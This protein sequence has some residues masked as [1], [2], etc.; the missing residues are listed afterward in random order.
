MSVYESNK[1]RKDGVR[2]GYNIYYKDENIGKSKRIT[3]ETFKTQKEALIAERRLLNRIESGEYD[4]FHGERK[5]KV[6]ELFDDFIVYYAKTGVTESTVRITEQSM[7][8]HFIGWFGDFYINKITSAHL[9]DFFVDLASKLKNYRSFNYYITQFFEYAKSKGIITVNPMDNRSKLKD[10]VDGA[11]NKKVEKEPVHY[12]EKELEVVLNVMKENLPSKQYTYFLL[13]AKTGLRKSEGLALYKEDIDLDNMRITVNKTIT[14]DRSG[15][16][17]TADGTKSRA[18]NDKAPETLPLDPELK[19]PLLE[20]IEKTGRYNETKFFFPS[21]RG[22]NGH[23]SMTAPDKWLR[24]FYNKHMEELKELGVTHRIKVHGFRH[25]FV[26]ILQ[27]S[28][29]NPNVIMYLTRHANLST[30]MDYSHFDVQTIED[31]MN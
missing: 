8:K 10:T 24:T 20:Y 2:W 14:T 21:P 13:L 17:I 7:R 31:L 29:Y 11:G 3:K 25:T 19:E 16:T 12:T 18:I 27:A 26:S 9:D 6:G 1:K 15:K 5:E 4:P 28:N 22:K 30:T 23:L